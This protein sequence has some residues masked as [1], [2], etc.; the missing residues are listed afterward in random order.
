MGIILISFRGLYV[1]WPMVNLVAGFHD[2]IP[3]DRGTKEA[4]ME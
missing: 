2:V 3:W 4:A 1:D